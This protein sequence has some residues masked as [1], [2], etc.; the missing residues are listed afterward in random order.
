MDK[1]IEQRRIQD[2]RGVKLFA[3]DGGTDHGENPRTNNRA[4]PECSERPG[5]ERF[6]QRVLGKF[7]V[8]DQLVDRFGCEQLLPQRLGSWRADFLSRY[9]PGAVQSGGTAPG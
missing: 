6:L 4:D 2:R 9:R 5:A 1:V 8:A 3:R 7:R